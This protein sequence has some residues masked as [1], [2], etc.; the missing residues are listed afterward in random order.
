MSVHMN[1]LS[2]RRPEERYGGGKHSYYLEACW[3]EK[4]SLGREDKLGVLPNRNPRVRGN[5]AD[6]RLRYG[7][8]LLVQS[9]VETAFAVL[10]LRL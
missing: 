7:G 2:K 4:F 8:Q 6:K 10:E 9:N 3:G 1:S 5:E